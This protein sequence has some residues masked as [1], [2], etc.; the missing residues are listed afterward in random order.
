MFDTRKEKRLRTSE[1]IQ[2]RGSTKMSR[3]DNIQKEEKFGHEVI[4]I[5]EKY[6]SELTNIQIIGTLEA[7]IFVFSHCVS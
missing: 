7:I 2:L 5:V 6:Q 4:E 3:E 1:G